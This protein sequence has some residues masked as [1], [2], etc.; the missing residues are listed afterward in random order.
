VRENEIFAD[1]SGRDGESRNLEACHQEYEGHSGIHKGMAVKP[2]EVDIL[3]ED[4][5]ETQAEKSDNAKD[6]NTA[7]VP[8]DLVDIEILV[9]GN[10][11]GDPEVIHDVE[12]P[13]QFHIFSFGERLK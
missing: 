11:Q 1:E 7:Q 3:L 4:A 8:A 13:A 10:R 6:N 2:V 5:Q 9:E 12:N